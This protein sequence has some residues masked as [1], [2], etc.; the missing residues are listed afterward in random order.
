MWL[1]GLDRGGHVW[2]LG[3]GGC[4]CVVLV[5]VAMAGSLAEDS[6]YHHSVCRAAVKYWILDRFHARDC[7][8]QMASL[9]TEAPA[10]Q[11]GLVCVG[12]TA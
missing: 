3:R 2:I 11:Q 6:L 8:I 9:I 4:G 12:C 1:C 5:V 7:S 10:R